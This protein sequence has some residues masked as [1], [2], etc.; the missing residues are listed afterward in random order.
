MQNSVYVEVFRSPI[1]AALLYGTPAAGISQTLRRRTRNGIT[2]LSQRAPPIFGRAA[3][4]LGI[5]PHSSFSFLHYS[6][7]FF[8]WFRAAELAIRQL[9]GARIVSYRIVTSAAHFTES[10]K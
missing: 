2:E 7:C 5:G 6:F 1:L 10:M 4:T 9:L 8:F 3:I